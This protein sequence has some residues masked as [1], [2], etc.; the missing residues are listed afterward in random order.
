MKVTKYKHACF[1]YTKG[2]SSIIVDPGR[3]TTD[4]VVPKSVAAIIITHQHVDHCDT[5]LIDTI[6]ATHPTVTI[7]CP[8]DVASQLQGYPTQVVNDGFSTEI[9]GIM[10]SFYG[11]NHTPVHP[12]RPIVQNV[13][14][15]I[16]NAL[17]YPGDSFTMPAG[18]VNTLAL[19][20][21][22]PWMKLSEAIDF[23]RVVKP[24][25]VFPTHDAVL[26]VDG[27][28]FSDANVKSF[29]DEANIRYERIDGKTVEL[30]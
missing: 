2:G 12:E 28:G 30:T 13:G 27:Q 26:S 9:A 15:M 25:F 16:D 10:V 11:E 29:T 8:A 6:L 14:V 4:L 21:G 22:G 3:L 23:M 18:P 24:Q 1:V 5:D 7:L 17:Y 20:L 19:P